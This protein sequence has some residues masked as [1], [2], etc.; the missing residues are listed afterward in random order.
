MAYTKFT[1][2][3]HSVKFGYAY[4]T[5]YHNQSPINDHFRMFET[6]GDGLCQH[7][8]DWGVDHEFLA[9]YL[10]SLAQAM[11]A[12]PELLETVRYQFDRPERSKI[13]FAAS[14]IFKADPDYSWREKKTRYFSM[15]ERKISTAPGKEYDKRYEKVT[16]IHTGKPLAIYNLVLSGYSNGLEKLQ[17]AIAI[18]DWVCEDGSHGWMERPAQ[19]CGFTKSTADACAIENA[20][21]TCEWI[22]KAAFLNDRAN[23]TI[24]RAVENAKPP[25]CE[26]IPDDTQE[27]TA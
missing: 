26:I 13:E 9:D 17:A 21:E 12:D 8:G 7:S 3:A 16:D 23:S 4:D 27:A 15:Q 1:S 22:L 11:L 5:G 24:K 6:Y 18:Y 25:C 10:L 20:Y 2:I 19:F 14:I